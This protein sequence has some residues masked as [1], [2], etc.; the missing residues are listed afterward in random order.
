MK[1]YKPILHAVSESPL[2]HFRVAVNSGAAPKPLTILDILKSVLKPLIVVVSVTMVFACAGGNSKQITPDHLTS[3]MR[4]V[5]KG[6][7]LYQRGCYKRSLEHYLRANEKFSLSDQ[8]D[9]VAMSLNNIGNVYRALGDYTSAILFFDEAYHTYRRIQDTRAMVRVLSNKAATLLEKE[10]FGKAESVMENAQDL[11][12]ESGMTDRPLTRNRGIL[13]AKKGDY[14]TAEK[15]LIDSLA[16]V[17]PTNLPEV[18]ATN[19]AIANV[20]VDTNRHRK[21]IG[22]LEAALSADQ[23]AGFYRGMADD[24]AAIGSAYHQLN[25]NRS[26][27][28]Y[29]QRSLKIYALIGNR[30]KV[31]EVLDQLESIGE[32]TELDLDVTRHFVERWLKGEADG[33]CE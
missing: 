12:L 5:K 18:A 29:Y 6:N 27:G 22:F 19:V 9:G 16:A 17:D 20:L 15:I 8:M 32:M 11:A 2:G 7:D 25:D 3:G 33:P 30:E 24:L 1:T 4:Q 14:Q 21:A 23:W 10:E 28:E 31:E 13:V 26:A